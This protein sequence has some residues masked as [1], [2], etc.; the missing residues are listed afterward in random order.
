METFLEFLREV[1][2]GMVRAISAYFI[3]KTFFKNEENHLAPS[4]AK[5]WFS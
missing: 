4:E 1:V 5:G 2:K 3:Q